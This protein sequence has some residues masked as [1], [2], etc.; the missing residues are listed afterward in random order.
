MSKCRHGQGGELSIQDSRSR[1]MRWLF[2]L[3][4]YT[5]ESS[6][7]QRIARKD[8]II[9]YRRAQ[10]GPREAIPPRMLPDAHNYRLGVS[11]LDPSRENENHSPSPT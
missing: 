6:K 4:E 10:S 9:S 7:K 8:V 3:S 5:G 1:F 2:G 11:Q